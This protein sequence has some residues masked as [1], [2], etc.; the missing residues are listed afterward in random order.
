MGGDHLIL[1][2]P[3]KPPCLRAE[4]IACDSTRCDAAAAVMLKR[5]NL[6]VRPARDFD[7]ACCGGLPV[8]EFLRVAR[9]GNVKVG[10]LGEIF[11]LAIAVGCAEI[12]RHT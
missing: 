3:V 4:A 8:L 2:V 7:D 10:V 6:T 11:D 5:D 12:E 1:C 9:G